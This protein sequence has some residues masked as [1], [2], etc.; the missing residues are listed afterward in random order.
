[1]GRESIGRGVV[2]TLTEGVATG[3]CGTITQVNKLE[4]YTQ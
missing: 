4:Q 1:M 2:S 3:P